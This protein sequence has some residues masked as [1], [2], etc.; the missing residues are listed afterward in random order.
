MKLSSL[1]ILAAALTL[2]ACTSTPLDKAPVSDGT[3]TP[4]GPSNSDDSS[5]KG[6]STVPNVNAGGN[7]SNTSKVAMPSDRSVYFEYDSYEIQAPGRGVVTAQS[8]YLREHPEA[9]VRIEG[10]ADERGGSE[11]NLALGQ[12]RADAVRKA[13]A[14]QGVPDKQMESVSFG[15][16]KPLAL[17]HDEDS[18]AKNRRADV[19]YQ[20]K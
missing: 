11:Y 7:T 19:N 17:G 20:A 15:K 13:L 4:A 9:Q 8:K 2:A 16:E 5:K 12:K 3:T 1:C 6:S 18:W 14:L 10:N